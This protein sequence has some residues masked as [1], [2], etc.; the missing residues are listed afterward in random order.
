M[1]VRDP[2]L[3][4][5]SDFDDSS[6]HP[7]KSQMYANGIERERERE[8]E[9]ESE[10]DICTVAFDLFLFSDLCS[11]GGYSFAWRKS[12]FA[13]YS[14]WIDRPDSISRYKREGWNKCWSEPNSGG[15]RGSRCLWLHCWT[16]DEVISILVGK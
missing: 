3:N 14:P 5:F 15:Q 2:F 12:D 6:T 13:S 11:L 10:R 1:I 8:R 16:G 7:Q 9:R 4:H